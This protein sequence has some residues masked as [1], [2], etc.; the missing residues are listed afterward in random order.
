MSSSLISWYRMLLT[1]IFGKIMR[2]GG[3]ERARSAASTR[4]FIKCLVT[5]S[6]ATFFDTTTAYPFDSFGEMALKLGEENRR[7]IEDVP[8]NV[9]R[10]SRSRCGNTKN[11][12]VRRARPIRRRFCTILRP[13]LVFVR[14]RNPCVVALLRFF[15]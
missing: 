10:G 6:R 7:P 8:E 4:R 12:T 2:D 15:G 5:E 3:R 1:V 14:V 13:E 11:Q 9:A